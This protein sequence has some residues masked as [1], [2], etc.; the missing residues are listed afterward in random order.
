MI[1][2]K[3]AQVFCETSVWMALPLFSAL[4]NGKLFLA[5]ALTLTIFSST[6]YWR[7][8]MRSDEANAVW[9]NLDRLGVVLVLSQVHIAFWPPLAL[10]FAAGAVLQRMR[11]KTY[12]W[13]GGAGGV[14][15]E[16]LPFRAQRWH[17][18]CHVLCRYV[19]FWA[20]CLASGHVAT[21]CSEDTAWRFWQC[22]HMKQFVIYS[23]LYLVH[24]YVTLMIVVY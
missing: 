20:C 16:V 22:A 4:R 2:L 15:R 11:V 17:F 5:G 9:H 24:V 12:V 10:L 14:S 13:G 6:Q 1:T 23:A 7:Q 19:A 18:W 8:L 21:T 3:R